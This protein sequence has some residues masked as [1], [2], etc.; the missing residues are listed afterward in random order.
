MCRRPTRTPGGEDAAF[1]RAIAMLDQIN[2]MGRTP[3]AIPVRIASNAG[4]IEAAKR[5]GVLAIVPCVE[6][7]F[8]IGADL[9]RIARVPG[10]GSGLHDAD[11]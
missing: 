5:D 2:R 8:A 10:E 6:N 4:A 9:S 1:D 7:G 3:S 11:P